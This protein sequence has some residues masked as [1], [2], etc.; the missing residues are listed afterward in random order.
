[1]PVRLA[2]CVA[3]TLIMIICPLR[4]RVVRTCTVRVFAYMLSLV[5][6]LQIV[7]VGQGGIVAYVLL[8]VGVG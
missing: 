1:M 3:A 7:R 8:Q 5:S 6:A 4:A 2:N